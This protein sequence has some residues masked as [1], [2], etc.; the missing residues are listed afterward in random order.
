MVEQGLVSE[1]VFSFWLN[2]N[3]QE[4]KG[5]ELIFGGMD[6]PEHYIG[7][8]TYVPVTRKAYWQ[9]DMGD[10][11]IDGQSTGFCANSCAATANLGTSL[12]VDPT[13]IVT[14]INQA[15]R[16]TR[17]MNQQCKAVVSQYRD[18]MIETILHL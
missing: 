18:A 14:A 10:F 9:F 3:A 11:L 1:P 4:E 2:R 12:M 17:V 8:H 5:G 13:G 15:I 16:A 7:Q 6:D